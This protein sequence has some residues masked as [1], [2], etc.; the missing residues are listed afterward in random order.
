M[1]VTDKRRRHNV[2][3][4][5][6]FFGPDP[7]TNGLSK[8]LKER[9]YKALE[10]LEMA[11]PSMLL[12]LCELFAEH[13]VAMEVLAKYARLHKQAVREMTPADVAEATQLVRDAFAVQEVHES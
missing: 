10:S 1:A 13:E 5:A 4:M 12:K 3:K 9:G 8:T 2:E 11:S 6:R 7:E